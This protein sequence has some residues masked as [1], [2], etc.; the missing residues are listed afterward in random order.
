M[1]RLASSIVPQYESV[2]VERVKKLVPES[3]WAARYEQINQFESMLASCGTTILKF[4]LHISKD[5]Q[6]E[7]MIE[8]IDVKS[9]NWKFNPGDL[10]DRQLWTITW[11]PT[12][13]RSNAARPSKAPW[14]VVPANHKWYR[15]Y[16]VADVL[17]R[18]LKAM[19]LEYPSP[20]KGL[21]KI[22]IK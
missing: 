10:Q 3:V 12:T 5:E 17:V 21:N 16:V 15:N 6:K 14:Y 18:A 9:K 4:F 20:P 19:D 8:R 11:T 1:A 22:E 2:L 7:R 13:M